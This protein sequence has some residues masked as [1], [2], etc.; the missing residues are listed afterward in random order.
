MESAL[1]VFSSSVTGVFVP[2][3]R[4]LSDSYHAEMGDAWLPILVLIES[5]AHCNLQ[6]ETSIAVAIVTT[7]SKNFTGSPP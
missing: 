7:K 2:L 6:W 4:Q 3:I 5:V 1:N